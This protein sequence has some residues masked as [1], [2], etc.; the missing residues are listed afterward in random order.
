MKM[1]VWKNKVP[2]LLVSVFILLLVAEFY[3]EVP[4]VI[5]SVNSDLRTFGALIAAFAMLLG[6]ANLTKVF[7][8]KIIKKS[9]NWEYAVLLLVS[10]FA[11]IGLGLLEG[12]KG[13]YFLWMY[14]YIQ[15]PPAAT[16]Y[17]LIG[18]YV[19]FAAYRAFRATNIES[20]ILLFGAFL[21]IMWGSSIGHYIWPG[22]DS[23]YSWIVDVPN[24]AGFRG[25]SIAVAV[26]TVAVGAA[27]FLH[28]QTL[29]QKAGASEEG[30]A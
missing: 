6:S 19:V 27:L 18:F 14:N 15:V 7:G 21:S 2:S 9:T 13:Y 29:F 20:S 28:K 10:L 25:Y 4:V 23:V 8:T 26:A 5:K 16:V 17:A 11:T 1:S 24:T 12:T 3:I 30:E 22:I